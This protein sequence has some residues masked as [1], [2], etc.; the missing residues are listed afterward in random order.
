M[1]SFIK[2]V[3]FTHLNLEEITKCKIVYNHWRKFAKIGYGWRTFAQSQ[4]LQ[5]EAQIIVEFEFLYE[6]SNVFYFVFVCY[7]STLFYTNICKFLFIIL[8]GIF[9]GK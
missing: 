2:G 7:L 3:G 4:N 9:C 8:G 1:Y 6:T 5:V